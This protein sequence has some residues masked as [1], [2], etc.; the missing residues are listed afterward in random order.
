MVNTCLINL[1]RSAS[2]YIITRC[3]LHATSKGLCFIRSCKPPFI[4][5]RPWVPLAS[6]TCQEIVLEE[7]LSSSHP[8]FQI[9]PCYSKRCHIL[10]GRSRGR[11]GSMQRTASSD[12]S[13]T[14]CEEKTMKLEIGNMVVSRLE[15]SS[16][17]V[18]D[19]MPVLHTNSK[20]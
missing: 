6:F 14:M 8:H 9:S 20:P 18:Q 17:P 19:D 2:T 13:V 11:G 3:L 7:W 12:D 16:F 1:A 10:H 4:L 5:A 15:R